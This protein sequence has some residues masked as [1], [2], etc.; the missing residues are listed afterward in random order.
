LGEGRWVAAWNGDDCRRKNSSWFYS[1]AWMLLHS[2]S[3]LTVEVMAQL[4]PPLFFFFIKKDGK[5]YQSIVLFECLK[6]GQSWCQDQT[7]HIF[8]D[9]MPGIVV[10]LMGVGSSLLYHCFLLSISMNFLC[11]NRLLAM[12][13]IN[14]GH[15][16]KLFQAHR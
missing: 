11:Q 14:E 1:F 4:L 3:G 7:A 8:I 9:C 15:D 16:D 2:S 5:F 10:C 13:Y 6:H 12:N